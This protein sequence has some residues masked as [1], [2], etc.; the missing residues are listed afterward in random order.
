LKGKPGQRPHL[1]YRGHV[2]V[3]PRA[4]C[5]RACLAERAEGHEGDALA[6]ILD[7]ARFVLPGLASVG[8]DQGF[9]AERVWEGAA[10]RRIVA[11][12]PPQKTMLPRN[13]CKPRTNAQRLA[14]EARARMK[15]ERGVWAY[16]QRMADAEGVI[17]G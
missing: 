9:A 12:V 2:A 17:A 16:R 13:G 10:E 7:R 4:R 8:A 11:Y 6:P 1:V 14:L 5:V 15:S 3:D